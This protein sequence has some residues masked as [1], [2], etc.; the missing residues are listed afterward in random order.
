MAKELK[1]NSEWKF[2]EIFPKVSAYTT[3]Y[4]CIKGNYPIRQS[5]MS[6]AWADEIVVLDGGSTD[7]TLDELKSLEKELVDK[8]KVYEI[9]ID[10]DEPGCDGQQKAL[11]RAMCSH[12]YLVQFDIDEIALGS[13]E[14]WLRCIKNMP[15][16]VDILNLLVVEPIGDI[17]KLR[18][19]KEHTPW[20]W[21]IFRNKN[22][23]T[24]G[25]PS[26]DR[27]EFNGKVYS[28]GGSDGCFPVNIVTN[29][30]YPSYT[31]G[32][33]QN[34]S[35][36]KHEESYDEY[37]DAV[38]EVLENYP[39]I[40][41]LGH[42]DLKSKLTHYVN[43]WHSMWCKLYN[44]DPDDSSNNMYFPDMTIEDITES[45]INDKVEEIK[46]S[47]PTVKC[48]EISDAYAKVVDLAGLTRQNGPQATRAQVQ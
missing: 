30:L 42:V 8:L 29:D 35:K 40:L 38:K 22:E 28:K 20:K 33:I 1:I 11:S 2:K 31:P 17:N 18:L 25:I 32:Y 46:N 39:C 15:E 7:G 12:K 43:S 37:A 23:I 6:F 36:L 41:H 27:A 3:T 45:L 26:H 13:K 47:T 16:E 9:P 21:R 24:H 10:L 5:L 44:K 34:I 48:D 4:N 14:S 19:N